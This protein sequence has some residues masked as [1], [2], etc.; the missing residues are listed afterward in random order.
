MMKRCL[1]PKNK[2]WPD[3]GGRGIKVCDEWHA[4]ENFLNDM[5]SRPVGS[6]IDRI[7]NNGPYQ[8][9][10]CKWST[11]IEQNRNTR[12]NHM[13]SDGA[14]TQTLQEWADSIGINHSS[15]IG[16]LKRGWP[17]HRALSELPNKNKKCEAT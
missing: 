7:D 9:D 14:K 13:L 3:Y 10:N 2:S 8:K 17:L 11:R 6:T 16:R 5:G 15:L 4:F 1:N 12:Q